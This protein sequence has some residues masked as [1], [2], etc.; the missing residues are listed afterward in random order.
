MNDWSRRRLKQKFGKNLHILEAISSKFHK[1]S[2]KNTNSVPF[3]SLFG[4][5]RQKVTKECNHPQRVQNFAS[6]SAKKM[7]SR[8]AF[9]WECKMVQRVHFALYYVHLAS[10]QSIGSFI[11]WFKSRSIFSRLDGTSDV[12]LDFFFIFI[13]IDECDYCDISG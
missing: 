2:D 6:K 7:H 1:K 11:F 13:Y 9:F 12:E 5:N 10:L 4:E 8:G 3:K